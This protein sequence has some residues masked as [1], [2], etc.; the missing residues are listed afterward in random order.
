MDEDGNPVQIGI[1]T[2]IGLYGDCYINYPPA[3]T[4]VSSFIGWIEEKTGL[5]LS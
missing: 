4:R 2:S 1:A 5:D 3:F